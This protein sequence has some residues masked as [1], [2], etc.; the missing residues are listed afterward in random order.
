MALTRYKGKTVTRWMSVKVSQTFTKGDIV[1]EG[2]S[3]DAGTVVPATSSTTALSHLGVIKITIA[4][5]DANYATARLVP[6]EVP[7]EKNVEWLADFTTGL[8]ATDRGLEV[9]LTSAGT[10]NR[11]ASSVKVAMVRTVNSLV[12]GTVVL[13]LQG[14]Y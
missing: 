5:T 11:A 10:L 3:G 1:S 4:A 6:V 2:T 7:I 13:K 14:S 12:Q 9:D 8:V